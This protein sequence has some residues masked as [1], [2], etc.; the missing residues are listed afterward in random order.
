MKKLMEDVLSILMSVRMNARISLNH[1]MGNA[2]KLED[3]F[4]VMEYVVQGSLRIKS[5]RS[6]SY[7][8][9]YL[10]LGR[11]FTLRGGGF[12]TPYHFIE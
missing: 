10:W 2:L 4:S 11:K 12:N 6:F 3:Q 7:H 8:Q 9:P 1:V 5:K